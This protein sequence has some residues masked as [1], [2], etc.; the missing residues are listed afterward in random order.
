MSNTTETALRAVLGLGILILL[1]GFE[2]ILFV[3][4]WKWFVVPLG[5]VEISLAWALGLNCLVSIFKYDYSKAKADYDFYDV[6]FT[7]MIFLVLI[8]GIGSIVHNLM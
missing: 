3:S 5:V 4:L 1:L 6:V 7:K 8:L 2:A